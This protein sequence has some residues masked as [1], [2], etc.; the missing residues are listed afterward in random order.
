MGPGR[1]ILEVANGSRYN[2]DVSGHADMVSFFYML[3][4]IPRS[5]LVGGLGLS[6]LGVGCSPKILPTQN[7]APAKPQPK[8]SANPSVLMFP[9][10]AKPN[11]TVNEELQS[12]LKNFRE[13]TSLRTEF[14]MTTSQGQVKGNFS[15]IR[16]NR[17]KG[18]MT[19]SGGNLNIVVVDDNLYLQVGAGKWSNLSNQPS[20][21]TLT[22][23]LKR[24]LSGNSTFDAAS[25]STETLVTKTR[26]DAR[27]CDS[28]KTT[29]KTAEGAIVSIEICAEKG[30]PRYVDMTTDQGPVHI[31]YTDYNTLFLIE[32]P[33]N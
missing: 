28:Y 6:L 11:P 1:Q 9:P 20:S 18:T 13:A 25:A 4:R 32:K 27:A 2:V 23:T 3:S 5:F 14:D 19:S 16:P 21:R 24:A 31:S 22:D 26:D 12:I 30:L 29:A 15:F 7:P 17:F 33:V 8:P 10:E